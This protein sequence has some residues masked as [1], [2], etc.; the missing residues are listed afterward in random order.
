M[1]KY[2]KYLIFSLIFY[3]LSISVLVIEVGIIVCK[4]TEYWYFFV[5]SI[6]ALALFFVG[7]YFSICT[8]QVK[9]EEQFFKMKELR[10]TIQNI[11]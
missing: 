10:K 1:E 8:K 3:W 7:L 11:K 5:V 2:R 9:V 4:F 6:L